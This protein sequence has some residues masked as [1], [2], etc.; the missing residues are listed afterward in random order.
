VSGKAE[1][2]LHPSQL[3]Y[4]EFEMDASGA[5]VV[6]VNDLFVARFGHTSESLSETLQWSDGGGFLPWGGDLVARL[7]WSEAD[8]LVFLQVL[9]VKFQSIGP[10]RHDHQDPTHVHTRD[11]LSAY[12][13]DVRVANASSSSSSF[14]DE[15]VIPCTVKALHRE[16]LSGSEL[17][18][19][20]IL[21]FEPM[22]E[23]GPGPELPETSSDAVEAGLSRSRSDDLEVN[24][25]RNDES[26]ASSKPERKRPRELTPKHTCM[27]AVAFGTTPEEDLS[28]LDTSWNWQTFESILEDDYCK[29]QSQPLS[30]N[31]NE[32]PSS[33]SHQPQEGGSVTPSMMPE[34]Q[35]FSL[36]GLKAPPD[37]YWLSTLLDWT[38]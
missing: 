8:V 30:G 38:Q 25:P 12:V 4:I 18:I 2:F 32:I 23:P 20:V 15:M 19:T 33:S 6:R 26:A 7:I 27:N 3:P 29:Q 11:I 37:E 10:P 16:T 14:A 13:F 31:S 28:L 21:E 9:A 17:K 1:A 5:R 35:P 24:S 36:E 34:V 22:G